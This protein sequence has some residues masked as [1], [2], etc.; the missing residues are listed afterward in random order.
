MLAGSVS[1]GCL[2]A[3]PVL[4][5]FMSQLFAIAAS[6]RLRWKALGPPCMYAAVKDDGRKS[7]LYRSNQSIE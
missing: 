1:L 4:A 3:V 2:V 6:T 5:R 7:H